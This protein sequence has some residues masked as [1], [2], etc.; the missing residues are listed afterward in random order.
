MK[1]CLA[2]LF[3]VSLAVTSFKLN[4]PI[5]DLTTLSLNFGAIVELAIKKCKSSGCF[6]ME[7]YAH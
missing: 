3:N 6:K 1:V 7:S 4:T 2:G 5:E